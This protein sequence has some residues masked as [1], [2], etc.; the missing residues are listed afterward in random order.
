MCLLPFNNQWI[1]VEHLLR[2]VL[3]GAW[4]ASVHNREKRV[5]LVKLSFTWERQTENNKQ[6]DRGLH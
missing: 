3:L 6:V 1:F 4:V 5:A 2:T